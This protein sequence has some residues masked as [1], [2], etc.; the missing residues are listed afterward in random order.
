MRMEILFQLLNVSSLN[1]QNKWIVINDN[2]HIRFDNFTEGL[3]LLNDLLRQYPNRT[4]KLLRED[5]YLQSNYYKRKR[6]KNA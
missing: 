1:M 6:G 3:Q 2:Q 4:I 5:E